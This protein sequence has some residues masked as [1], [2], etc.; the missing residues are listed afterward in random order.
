MTMTR[1][2]AAT[3]STAAG[4]SIAKKRSGAPFRH[5]AASASTAGS[6]TRAMVSP[7]DCLA[8]GITCATICLSLIHI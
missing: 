7:S 8:A 2:A 4:G 1:V 5:A 3:I 6:S